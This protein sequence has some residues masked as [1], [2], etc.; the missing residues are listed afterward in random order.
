MPE[1]EDVQLAGIVLAGGRGARLGGVRKAD[2][3]RD[4]RALLDRA[5]SACGACAEVVVV[6]DA[7]A[8]GPQGARHGR[9]RFVRE[10]PAYGGPAAGLLTGAAALGPAVRSLVVLAVDMPLVDDGTV[11]RLLDAAGPDG[12]DGSALVDATGR[13]QLA[14]VL[15][16]AALARV[17]P[18]PDAWSGLPLHRLLAGL[19]LVAVPA[20]A[21]EA[22]DV[23]TW[24]DA[25][26]LR[27]E[28]RPD[29]G[30]PFGRFPG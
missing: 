25:A 19:R 3:R 4:G 9:V 8:D 23:D 10:E 20:R 30:S 16:R 6:G 28:P 14:M 5:L 24:D 29:Q 22:A 13:R 15:R 27:V 17:A 21:D 1:A 11:R 2:L 7:P 26:R 18:P 12:A